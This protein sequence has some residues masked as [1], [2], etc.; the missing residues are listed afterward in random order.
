MVIERNVSQCCIALVSFNIFTDVTIIVQEHKVKMLAK[1]VCTAV[2]VNTK[3]QN[4]L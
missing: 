2:M 3:S 4:P 1:E